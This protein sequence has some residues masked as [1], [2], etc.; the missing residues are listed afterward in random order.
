MI[1]GLATAAVFYV[2]KGQLWEDMQSFCSRNRNNTSSS[3]HNM[4]DYEEVTP[5]NNIVEHGLKLEE[6]NESTQ[7]LDG[8]MKTDVCE[9]HLTLEE[10]NES[11]SLLIHPK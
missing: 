10:H 3:G 1:F 7:V 9:R 6:K 8:S 5:D 4:S 11:I 2:T